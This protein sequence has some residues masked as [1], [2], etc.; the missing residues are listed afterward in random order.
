[1]MR[2]GGAAGTGRPTAAPQDEGP[3]CALGKWGR[4]EPVK[5]IG[6]E[7]WGKAPTLNC[8]LLAVRLIQPAGSHGLERSKLV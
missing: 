4:S 2:G 6:C 3:N 5:P 8:I 1:M 7:L